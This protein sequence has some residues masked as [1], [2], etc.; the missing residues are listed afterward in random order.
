MKAGKRPY[1]REF[2]AGEAGTSHYYISAPRP[3]WAAV[4][5]K[6]ASQGT[7]VRA[8]ILRLLSAWVE[9]QATRTRKRP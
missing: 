7:S 8:V 3:L 1:T 6:A 9:Q 4:K 5:A 2:L